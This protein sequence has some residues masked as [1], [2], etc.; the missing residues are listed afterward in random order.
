MSVSS[1]SSS[2]DNDSSSSSEDDND[3]DRVSLGNEG[4]RGLV[5][6]FGKCSLKPSEVWLEPAT[7][8]TSHLLD[9]KWLYTP[10]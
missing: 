6:T 2:E 3:D 8:S 10:K 7:S 5:E 1:R 9:F 4:I